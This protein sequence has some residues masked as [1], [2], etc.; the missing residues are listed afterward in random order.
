[1]TRAY[2]SHAAPFRMRESRRSYAVCGIP[3]LLLFIALPK[4][5]LTE[6]IGSQL[7]LYILNF[8]HG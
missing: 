7:C 4:C 1:M 2:A 8:G 6:L 3:G 5:D